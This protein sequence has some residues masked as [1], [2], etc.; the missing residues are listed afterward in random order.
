MHT[1]ST[2]PAMLDQPG[3][4][5]AGE[6]L[7]VPA[8]TA[9]MRGGLIAADLP[10]EVLQFPSGHSNLTYLIRCGDQ[11]WVL[12][13]PPFGN[14][15]KSAHDMGREYR[16][17]SRLGDLFPPAPRPVRYCDDSAVLG[18]PFYLM[19]RRRGLILRRQLPA[20]IIL[21]ADQLRTMCLP[22]ID[23]LAELHAL[24][25]E[26]HGLT[27]LGK[28]AGYAARQVTGWTKRYRDAETERLD[29]IDTVAAW[30]NERLPGDRGAC[31]VHNDYKFDNV[32]LDPADP[33]CVVAVLDWEMATLGDPLMDLG[34][35][36]GYWVEPGDPEELR[37]TAM[38]P[39]LLP[40]ALTRRDVVERY[41]MRSGRDVGGIVYYYVFGLFKIAVI[42]Q[43]IY[44]RYVRG[45]TR[46]E[47]F[48]TLNFR[49]KALAEHAAA[50]I[51]KGDL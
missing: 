35:T 41:A 30:L 4:V 7:P 12:R 51:H 22:L 34:T 37:T 25:V 20:G 29:A 18:A 10:V 31:V 39:T 9:Y 8:L 42:I 1:A 28:P 43:Q 15:V 36:L 26:R 27:D 45:H 50:V 11:E 23:T 19:E 5:R 32:I 49:V 33:S 21:G 3:P 14:Q 2:N 17:L 47:R 24:D 46:D 44:A 40:G 13:R 38:G 6:E 16:M 48:A